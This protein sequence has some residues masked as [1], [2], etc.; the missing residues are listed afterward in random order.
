VKVAALI[1]VGVGSVGLVVT[2]VLMRRKLDHLRRVKE[3]RE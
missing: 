1:L 2:F 3:E